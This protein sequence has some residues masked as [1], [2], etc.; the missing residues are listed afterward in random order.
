MVTAGSAEHGLLAPE[1]TERLEEGIGARGGLASPSIPRLTPGWHELTVVARGADGTAAGVR[2]MV[3]VLA[4]APEPGPAPISPSLLADR[5][6]P[7]AHVRGQLRSST[8]ATTGR[9]A[10]RRGAECSTPPAEAASGQR[11]SPPRAPTRSTPSTS[12]PEVVEH[13]RARV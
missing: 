7:E 5:Y 11:S 1:L 13:A 3:E 12:M 9:G 8:P 10:W 4:A 2:G 6:V